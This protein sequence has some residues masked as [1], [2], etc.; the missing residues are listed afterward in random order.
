MTEPPAG[1]FPAVMAQIRQEQRGAQPVFRLRWIDFA[2]SLFF[3]GMIGLALLLT[4]SLPPQARLSLAWQ[5]LLLQT[6]RFEWFLWPA[7]GLAAAACA[8][9]GVVFARTIMSGRALN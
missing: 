7:V 4:V 1:L 9:A 3:A 5:L 6:M 2:L 8:A